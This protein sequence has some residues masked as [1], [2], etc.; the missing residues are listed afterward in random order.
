MTTPEPETRP[1][2]EQV[3]RRRRKR[4]HTAPDGSPAAR[5]ARS[6][7]PRVDTEPPLRAGWRM[8]AAK[9]FA[10]NITSIR[11]LMLT[12]VLALA[13]GGAVYNTAGALRNAASDASGQPSLF[14]V[15]FTVQVGAIPKFTDFIALLGPVLGIM[16]GFY[17]INS[18]RASATLPRLLSQPIHRDD[19]IN[20][21]FVAGLATIAVILLA[22]VGIV[23]ALG[24]IQLGIIPSAEDVLRLLV[25][26]IL[27]ISYIG[28][29]LAFAIL[30]SVLFKSAA[31]AALAA[32]GVWFVVAAF[33]PLLVSVIGGVVS[34]VPPD[35]SATSPEAIANASFEVTLD[36]V[37]PIGLF[38]EA[39]GVILDPSK[40][41]GAYSVITPEQ[42]QG[43][44]GGLLSIDQSLLV[45]W[46]QFVA[47]IAGTVGVF[48]VAYVAF[49]R[50]EVR[51]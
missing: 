19:V 34:P 30:C 26:C 39:T 42:A 36:R 1:A 49:M 13:A 15:I 51:A 43:A 12:I 45:V 14:L 18:E 2:D 29:W 11:F 8:I 33:F 27:A 38:N 28:F 37:S 23:A 48:A 35:A 16:F 20:G 40:R 41:S 46:G 17:A 31:T 44:I 25:W 7:A 5:P 47:L 32:F 4:V 6:P 50:Q 22:V 3:K 24:V 10:D 21:K 9:E